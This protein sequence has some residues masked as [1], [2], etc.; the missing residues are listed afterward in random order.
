MQSD[1]L[2]NLVKSE[3]DLYLHFYMFKSISVQAYTLH[4]LLIKHISKYLK[5]PKGHF[6]IPFQAF[7]A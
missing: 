6:N 3:I 7:V 5:S 2:V 1:M 4:H